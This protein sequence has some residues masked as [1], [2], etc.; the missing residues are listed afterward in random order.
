M[1]NRFYR[2]A[3]FSEYH[4][5]RILRFFVEDSTPTKASKN[6]SLS[7]NT[8]N[9]VFV[10]IR[11]HFVALGLFY[12]FESADIEIGDDSRQDIRDFHKERMRT[13]FGITNPASMFLHRSESQ[14]RYNYIKIFNLSD[15]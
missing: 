4:F 15:E 6:I 1:R 5:K 9:T 12:D 8:I 7:L 10:K 11:M 13:R 2:N 14:W 3:K